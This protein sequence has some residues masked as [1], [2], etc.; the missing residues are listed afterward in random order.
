MSDPIEDLENFDTQGVNVNPLPAAE[1]RR[2]GN[3]MRRR[4]NALAAV[5]GVAAIALIA[6][7][8]ALTANGSP[9][10][11]PGP[12]GSSS[13]TPTTGSSVGAAWLQTIPGD[14]DLTA[15]PGDATFAYAARGGSVVDDITLCG[16]PSFSTR[17][18]DPVAPAVDTAGAAYSEAGTESSSGRTLALYSSDKLA[19]KIVGAI[20]HEVEVCP[21]ETEPG[22]APLVYDAVDTELPVDD[23]FVFTEQSRMDKDL[24]ADLTVYQVARVGNAIYLATS[25]TSAGGAQVADAEVRRMAALS[26]PV[27]SDMCVFAAEPCGSPS[28]VTSSP[29]V[30]PAVG[31][32]AVSA[33]PADF[34]I[35]DGYP[36]DSSSEGG[37]YGIQGPSSDA[38]PLAFRACGT[39]APTLE[40]VEQLSGGWTNPE[41][42]RHR[43]L[44]T[45]ATVAEAKGWVDQM[46][47]VY[48]DCPSED[49]G[50]GY[51]SLRTVLDGDL[52]DQ[53]ASATVQYELDG[54]MA[55]GLDITTVVRVG[56]AVLVATTYNEGSAGTDRELADQAASD[57]DAV[58]TLVD[59]MCPWT[60]RGC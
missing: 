5:G 32:G 44:T 35:L 36:D 51:T 30:S 56:R 14:F 29:S 23:S 53:S 20:R 43:Q 26:A 7:P 12:A 6:V 48:R 27:L 17:S 46:L 34:P 50:D 42:S 18:N 8:L 15:L 3:R 13:P 11:A 39:E 59:A 52:G 4:N 28:D 47:Q 2:R 31:E 41:D 1:V 40:G 60:E 25:H 22:R 45:F 21:T 24:L 33:I 38:K 49:G 9:H 10:S 55:P 58:T 57:A 37:D 19:A 16:R 54:G